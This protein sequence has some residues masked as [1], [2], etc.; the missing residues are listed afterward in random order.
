MS[1]Q[2]RRTSSPPKRLGTPITQY[3]SAVAVTTAD[4]DLAQSLHQLSLSTSTA[5]SSPARPPRSPRPSVSTSLKPTP[6]RSPSTP[7]PG[8][9]M[10]SPLH[11]PA[12]NRT[13][14]RSAT[15]TL[16]RKASL[17]SLHSNSGVTP[18]RRSSSANV[19]APRS[20]LGAAPPE[21]ALPPP[22]TANS[23]A[24]DHFKTELAAHHGPDATTPA[25]TIVI[26]Q[27]A[28]YGHRYSRPRTTRAGLSTI[29]ERPERIKAC[30]LGV[31]TAYVRLGERH[32]E[33]AHP[34]RPG[35]NPASVPFRIHKTTRRLS[36]TSQTV[37]N[38][39]GVKWMEELKTMCDSAEAKL[40]MNGKELL[41]PEMDRGPNAEAPQKFHE[42][43][44]YLCAES[45]NAMEGALGGVCEAVDAVFRPQGPKRA[46][47]AIRPPGHHCSASYPSGFCWVN[48]VHVGV[49]HG[50]LSHGLTHAAIIDFDLHH[51]DGSQSIA[52]QHNARSVGLP[53][54]AAWWKKTSIGYF[55]LHDINSYPC[56]MGD[57]EKVRNASICIDNAHGQNIWNVHLQPWRTEAEFFA[58]YESK[59]SILLE[60]TRAYLRN[61]TERLRA[62]GLN[63]RAAIFLSSG[64][65][66][67]EWEGAGMQRHN[68]NVPTEFY[69][70]LTR[71]VVRIAA[72]EGTSVEGR[73][74]SVLEGGYS[75]RALCSGILSHLCGLA[76]DDPATK[77]QEFNGLGYE[78]GQ[79]MGSVRGRDSS[80]GHVRKDSSASERGIRRYEPSWWS[81]SELQD[82]EQVMS[83]NS[84][85]EPKAHRITTPPAYFSPTQASVARAI[86]VRR[87]V[88]G[89]SPSRVASRPP[90]PPPPDV[91]WTVA[92]HELCKLLIP[93]ERQTDSCTHEDLNAEATKAR[94]DRQTVVSQPHPP[95]TVPA[96]GERA[97]TRMALRG[98]KA[99][100]ALPIDEES[101]DDP[102][103]RRRTVGGPSA[104]PKQPRQSGRRL[105][106]AS[107]LVSDN[108][109]VQPAP[110]AV[111]VRTGARP[112]TSLTIRPDSSMSARTAVGNPLAVKKTR[113]PVVKK[114][115]APRAPRAPKR[116]PSSTNANGPRAVSKT[117]PLSRTPASTSPDLP[118]A[119]KTANDMDSLTSDM[120][121]IKITLVTKAQKEARERERLAREKLKACD[122]ISVATPPEEPRRLVPPENLPLPSSPAQATTPLK[123]PTLSFP[124]QSSGFDTSGSH[125][126][127]GRSSAEL[128]VSSTPTYGRPMVLPPSSSP[129]ST[130]PLRSPARSSRNSNRSPTREAALSSSDMF[131]PYQPEG[132]A[133]SPLRQA[134]PP[135]QWLP[136]NAATPSVMRRADLPVFTSTSAIPFG[137]A[138]K[139]P[140]SPLKQENEDIWEV[141][142][143]PQ[144]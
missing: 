135:L 11:G 26:L 77:E 58:L 35:V 61:E 89:L 93:S 56:E 8:S 54:N 7:R 17:N 85:A 29:V 41:R 67:S 1:F 81:A 88:S 111:P 22:P 16:L 65:D 27:D 136:P 5:T 40:A 96:Q 110:P 137:G 129:R 21:M 32:V 52:W 98:R 3:P 143:T 50:V 2:S 115:P 78:M 30:V 119:D 63:S 31:S 105:S 126:S 12:A 87:S 4:R 69:A 122:S 48:N 100:A 128:P 74:I 49:M 79:R 91:H 132:P 86:T 84:V 64:F 140:S 142:E 20:P 25:E 60:K 92:T 114:E 125:Y 82:L 107:T 55:S 102:K 37:T 72:E 62:A 104:P 124:D 70:R 6:P 45:L 51:G 118:V 28:C 42:G 53:K 10:R 83:P 57:E 95:G 120:K 38:V 71:D 130:S 131:V 18:L 133:A 97:P 9:S 113:A 47:V 68:V 46:F 103:N 39:H 144:K 134:Q 36:L 15:P 14:S 66:A 23:I 112:G 24:S 106:A 101:E 139:P 34:I 99:K 43:D 13:P 33:G 141:P 116:L 73:I 76:G 109:P 59:Y 44:L 90:T 94:R 80:T 121:K 19:L 108:D 138:M 75:D 117:S 127:P 123:T